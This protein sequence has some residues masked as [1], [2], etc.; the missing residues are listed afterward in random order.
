[1]L[2]DVAI[3][4]FMR[5]DVALSLSL[6]RANPSSGTKRGN[7]RAPLSLMLFFPAPFVQEQDADEEMARW[8]GAIVTQ[9]YCLEHV[10]RYS[11]GPT[12]SQKQAAPQQCIKKWSKH[13]KWLVSGFKSGYPIATP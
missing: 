10:V 2:S 3:E 5:E 13:S 8:L 9:A 7:C 6:P 12:M 4:V 1:M 11:V